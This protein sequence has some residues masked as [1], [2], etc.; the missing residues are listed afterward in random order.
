MVRIA[1]SLTTNFFMGDSYKKKLNTCFVS[2]YCIS[3]RC[4]GSIM[5]DIKQVQRSMFFHSGEEL[6]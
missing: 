3:L 1:V 5:Y 6:K 4:K 2:H